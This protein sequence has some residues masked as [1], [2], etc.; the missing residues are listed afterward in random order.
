MFM[1]VEN[2]HWYENKWYYLWIRMWPIREQ[3]VAVLIVIRNIIV[4]SG[5]LF[6][7]ATG[8]FKCQ[9]LLLVEVV[10]KFEGVYT[11]PALLW[12]F[13]SMFILGCMLGKLPSISINY[14][15]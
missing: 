4:A 10:E 15:N 1:R 14:V 8:G 6:C 3:S 2:I 7:L 12:V 5:G 13:T 9:G 11:A